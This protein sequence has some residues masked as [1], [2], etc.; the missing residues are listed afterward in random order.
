[1]IAAWIGITIERKISSR[2]SAE[3][4]ITIPKNSGNLS[5]ST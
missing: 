4:R 5:E 3:S 1:M 2:S